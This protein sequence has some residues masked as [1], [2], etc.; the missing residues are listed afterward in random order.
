MSYFRGAETR[1]VATA[2]NA[3]MMVEKVTLALKSTLGSD[4]SQ[5]TRATQGVH[6]SS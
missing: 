6:T 4:H 3:T 1:A 5:A 2:K